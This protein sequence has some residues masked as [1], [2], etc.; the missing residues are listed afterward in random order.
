MSDRGLDHIES[1]SYGGRRLDSQRWEGDPDARSH[2]QSLAERI[3]AK[4]FARSRRGIAPDAVTAF[5]ADVAA[6]VECLEAELRRETVKAITLARRIESPYNAEGDI[7]AAFLAAAETKQRLIDEAHFRAIEIIDEANT[8]AEALI[9]GSQEAARRVQDDRAA[10][11]LQAEERLA[12][13]SREATAIE[14]L[15]HARAEAL[16]ADTAERARQVREEVD[17]RASEIIAAARNEA[18]IRITAAKRTGEDIRNAL[19]AQHE[20]LIERVRSLRRAVTNM[21]EDGVAHS[22]ELAAVI[23]AVLPAAN[24]DDSIEQAS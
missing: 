6:D 19:E 13:A 21:L 9:Q 14:D 7:Q 1:S 17:R 24:S 22:G 12:A 18:A 10:I 11:L 16:E 5:L 15:A 8:Q 3:L 20:D 23:S 2:M 4:Q